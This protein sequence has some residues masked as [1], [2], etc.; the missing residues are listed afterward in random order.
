MVRLPFETGSDK[1]VRKRAGRQC[2]CREKQFG[3]TSSV[4]ARSTLPYPDVAMS[5]KMNTLAVPVGQMVSLV[6]ACWWFSFSSEMQLHWSVQFD[7]CVAVCICSELFYC[8]FMIMFNL[9]FQQS[10]KDLLNFWI[11]EGDAFWFVVF[12][13]ALQLWE[14]PIVAQGDVS[15][16]P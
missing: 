6:Q 11:P 8:R 14:I 13:W 15:G 2:S 12:S 9:P 1:A 5:K 3:A 7:G 16:L 4:W 10:E